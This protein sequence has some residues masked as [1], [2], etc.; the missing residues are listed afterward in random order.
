MYQPA[1]GEIKG[2]VTMN[3]STTNTENNTTD[4]TNKNTVNNNNDDNENKTTNLVECLGVFKN[5]IDA[6]DACIQK[7]LHEVEN[8]NK[9]L[10]TDINESLDKFDEDLY[11]E[12]LEL[13]EKSLQTA[14][15]SESR[16]KVWIESKTLE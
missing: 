12:K 9:T 11:K 7:L 4:D 10:S 14:F 16:P 13:V 2:D 6:Y 1:S 8:K 15:D 3:E 5:E